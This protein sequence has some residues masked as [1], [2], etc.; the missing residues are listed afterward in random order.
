MFAFLNTH[1][2]AGGFSFY[3][4]VP[5]KFW[6]NTVCMEIHT[7]HRA[8]SPVPRRYCCKNSTNSAMFAS[9]FGLYFSTREAT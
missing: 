2:I 3:T 6:R 8:R 7:P 4:E 1:S 5:E 9:I